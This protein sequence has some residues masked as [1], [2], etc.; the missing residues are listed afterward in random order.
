MALERGGEWT[1]QKIN[2][3]LLKYP[4]RIRKLV[5]TKVESMGDEY[6]TKVGS[7]RVFS[8]ANGMGTGSGEGTSRRL[9]IEDKRCKVGA[10]THPKPKQ[11]D[12]NIERE[13]DHHLTGE[14]DVKLIKE[15][16]LNKNTI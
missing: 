6:R 4:Y 11:N 12:T 5:M 8:G 13:G 15:T 16:D 14:T 7:R 3:K 2:K 1:S 10:T 9:V